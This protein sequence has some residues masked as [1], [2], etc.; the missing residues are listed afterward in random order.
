M[1]EVPAGP[2]FGAGAGGARVFPVPR[3]RLGAAEQRYEGLT[4]P[5]NQS[6]F[7]LLGKQSFLSKLKA[8]EFPTVTP[9]FKA[10][11]F[12]WHKSIYDPQFKAGSNH[13]QRK[14]QLPGALEHRRTVRWSRRPD[15]AQG[16]LVNPMSVGTSGYE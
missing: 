2:C 12:S 10:L 7:R 1:G 3:A 13:K 6:R 16:D 4:H 15:I 8:L 5:R 9:Y 11:G 14:R